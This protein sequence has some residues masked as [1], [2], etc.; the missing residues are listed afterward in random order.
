VAPDGF[1]RNVNQARKLDDALNAAGLNLSYVIEII[2]DRK[3]AKDR[4]M[5]GGSA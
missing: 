1:P 5:D 3:M 4:I 2:L